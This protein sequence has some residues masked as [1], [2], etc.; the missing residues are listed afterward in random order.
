METTKYRF[1]NPNLKL[2]NGNVKVPEGILEAATNM[3]G[4]TGTL[5]NAITYLKQSAGST[6]IISATNNFIKC[7]FKDC[8]M[9]YSYRII[10]FIPVETNE[11]K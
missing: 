11:K 2:N 7:S 6:A 8:G 3:A 1:F 9:D 5:D 4:R 10:D